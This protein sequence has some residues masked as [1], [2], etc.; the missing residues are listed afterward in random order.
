MGIAEAMSFQ[1]ARHYH[2][3]RTH[4][5]LLLSG[6]PVLHTLELPWRENSQQISCIP[7]DTYRCVRTDNR[8]TSGGLEIPS[9][10]EVTNVPGRGGILFHVGNY[11]KDTQGCILLGL[12]VF[13]DGIRFSRKAFSRFLSL[14]NDVDEFE[15]S[16]FSI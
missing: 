13:G 8:K 14:T 15:L 4:G 6:I 9:T 16:I 12:Q 3:N 7:E 11:T 10:F 2:H 5:R 1:I